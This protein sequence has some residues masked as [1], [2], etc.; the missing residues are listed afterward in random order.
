MKKI[1]LLGIISVTLTGC[2]ISSLPENKVKFSMP[3]RGINIETNNSE[4][5]GSNLTKEFKKVDYEPLSQAECLSLKDS[6]GLKNC[7]YDND[8]LAGVAKACGHVEN[9]PTGKDL[10]N[11][12]KKVYH[13]NSEE[14]S[15]YG[16]RNDKMLKEIGLYA[17]DSHIFIWIGEEAADGVNGFVRMFA[18]RGSIPYYAPRDGSGYLAG[19]G[20]YKVNYGDTKYISTVNPDHDS[21]LAGLPN[22]DVLFAVCY[23]SK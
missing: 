21:N 16:T 12:A 5:Y 6:L 13:T 2:S 4:D 14:T 20:S 11:L 3:N 22:N 17:H 19:N 10:Q 9:I 7:P 1:L 18:S 8:H 15:I 23:M